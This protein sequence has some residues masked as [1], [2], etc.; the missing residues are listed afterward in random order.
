[1]KNF[2]DR[3]VDA[4]REKNSRVV[5]GLDPRVDKLPQEL[6]GQAP[7]DAILN[8]NK[9]IIDAVA[10]YAVAVKP[11]SA[12]YEIYGSAGVRTLEL[13][14]AYAR[15]KKLLT[16]CDV[17]R[18]DVSS[19]AEAYAQAYLGEGVPLAADSITVNPLFGEDGLEPFIKACE[20]SGTGLFVL[21][22]TSNKGSADFQELRCGE[23]TFSEIVAERLAK[24][25]QKLTG[26]AGWSSLGVVVG[27]TFPKDAEKIRALMPKNFFLLPG[28]G[29]QGAGAKDV[30]QSFDKD[31][32]GAV[33]TAS[34]S[35]MFAYDDPKWKGI[36][37]KDGWKAAIAAAAKAMRDEINAAR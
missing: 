1:M 6:R 24:W 23:K 25:G 18:G 2:A 28:Y 27:A 29:A 16:I 34:R 31:G 32:L 22:R 15:E 30:V 8:F 14:L 21:V 19:T 5:V 9:A 3:L 20:K 11:Q 33:V 12:F 35:V 4:V 13:T 10:P 37:A 36:A 17:K 26:A 7:C